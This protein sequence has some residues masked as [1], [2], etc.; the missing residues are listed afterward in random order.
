[1]R[2]LIVEDE[3]YLAEAVRDGLRL[4]A[5]AADIAGDGNSALELLG[6]NSYAGSGYPGLLRSQT[7]CNQVAVIYEFYLVAFRWRCQRHPAPHRP[8][9]PACLGIADVLAFVLVMVAVCR[10]YGHSSELD[11]H[12][13]LLIRRALRPAREGYASACVGESCGPVR[14]PGFRAGDTGTRRDPCP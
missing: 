13:S 1:M 5:I 12:T 10:H 9:S 4:E 7:K 6:I 2:V 3:P 8:P 14:S 11:D